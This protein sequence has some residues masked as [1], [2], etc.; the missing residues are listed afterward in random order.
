MLPVPPTL[1]PH[2][3]L[4]S[5]DGGIGAILIKDALAR[6]GWTDVTIS[7]AQTASALESELNA[8]PGGIVYISAESDVLQLA[9]GPQ[10]HFADGSTITAR[11]VL[12]DL[13]GRP[14][15]LLP[16]WGFTNLLWSMRPSLTSIIESTG[17]WRDTSQAR[18]NGLFELDG[19]PASAVGVFTVALWRALPLA[20]DVRDLVD[21][22]NHHTG[23]A[24]MAAMWP[25][26]YLVQVC[27]S[28]QPLLPG[29]P[30]RPKTATHKKASTA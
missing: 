4:V 10:I 9:D 1:P 29:R 24:S 21:H 6:R 7:K 27:G 26:L 25:D 14:F 8:M 13:S 23:T 28:G 16:D 15:L 12:H 3:L 5:L 22:V 19:R 30:L 17:S 11:Q 2:A 18:K 20:T